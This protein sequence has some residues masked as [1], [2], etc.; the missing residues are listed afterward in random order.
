MCGSRSSCKNCGSVKTMLSSAW[1]RTLQ[2]VGDVSTICTTCPLNSGF[3]VSPRT[4]A[5]QPQNSLCTTLYSSMICWYVLR[6]FV[7]GVCS[8]VEEELRDGNVVGSGVYGVFGNCPGNA[9]EELAGVDNFCVVRASSLVD[10]KAICFFTSVASSA[11]L[12]ILLSIEVSVFKTG[13]RCL[14]KCLSNVLPIG[15]SA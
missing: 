10:S 1:M 7:A 5:Q 15:S 9:E 8:N 4:T 6:G 13:A 2:S 12:D 14:P 11:V 3:S